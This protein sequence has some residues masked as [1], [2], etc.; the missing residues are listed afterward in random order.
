[1]K[2]KEIFGNVKNVGENFVKRDFTRKKSISMPI[3]GWDKFYKWF[4]TMVD[5]YLAQK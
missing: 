1:M 4:M 5:D 3:T 2:K